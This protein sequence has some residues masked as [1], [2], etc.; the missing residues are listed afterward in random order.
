MRIS[1]VLRA[2]DQ[3][4]RLCNAPQLNALLER[5]GVGQCTAAAHRSPHWYNAEIARLRA[6]RRRVSIADVLLAVG[7]DV[8]RIKITLIW[9]HRV[10][11]Y[12]FDQDR[13]I[14]GR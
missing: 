1:R 13:L 8:S 3:A 14:R 5:S 7:G 11:T 12:L 9:P 10:W 4:N 6:N 2:A